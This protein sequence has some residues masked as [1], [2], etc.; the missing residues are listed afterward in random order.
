VIDDCDTSVGM[1]AL[2]KLF[3][4]SSLFSKEKNC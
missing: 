3:P 2:P 1:Y 4:V